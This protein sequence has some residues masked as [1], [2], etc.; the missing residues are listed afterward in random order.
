MDR[1]T[2]SDDVNQLDYEQPRRAEESPLGYKGRN[3]AVFFTIAGVISANI[4][5]IFH[6]DANPLVLLWPVAM[7]LAIA[8]PLV[9]TI[10]IVH[11]FWKHRQVG[12]I[13]VTIGISV[14]NLMELAYFITHYY[15]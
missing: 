13:V 3:T 10:V 1:K 8:A 15:Q 12:L 6:P 4:A 11:Y 14:L 5:I 9:N 7:L 2:S